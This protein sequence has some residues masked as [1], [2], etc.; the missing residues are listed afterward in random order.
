[1]SQ[2]FLEKSPFGFVARESGGRRKMQ[3]SVSYVST[4]QL[5]LAQRGSIEW[6][7]AESLKI[8]NLLER[9]ESCVRP[10]PLPDSNR[11]IER[12]DRRRR[13]CHQPVVEADDGIPVSFLDTVCCRMHCGD[14]RLEMIG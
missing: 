9:L 2:P 10:V 8:R 6:I 14:C 13:D 5:Q 1:M 4:A 3:P 12:D 11:A 7:A